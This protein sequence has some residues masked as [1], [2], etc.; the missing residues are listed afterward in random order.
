MT[1][2]LSRPPTSRS[3]RP[4]RGRSGSQRREQRRAQRAARR[5]GAEPQG[6]RSLV[7]RAAAA[8]FGAAAVTLLACMALALVGWFLADGGAHGQTTDA[9]RV[10]AD[11]WLAGHGSGISVGGVPLGIIPLTVTA[12][13]VLAV[14]RTARR[15]GSSVEDMDDAAVAVGAVTFTGLYVVTAVVTAL[16]A[17]TGT[18]SAGVGRSILGALV[19]SGIA[20]T[21]GLASG[22]GRLAVWLERV[23]GWIRAVGTGAL[24]TVLTLLVCASVL[25]AGATLWGLNDAAEMLAGLRLS[26]GDYVAYLVASAFVAPNA[27]V[28]GAAW[29]LGPGFAVGTGTVISPTVVSLGPVPAFPLVAALPDGAQVPSWLAWVMAVPVGCAVVGAVLAQ[30]SYRVTAWDSAALRGFGSGLGAA[31][32]TSLAALVAGGPMGTGRMAEIGPSVSEVFVAATMAMS[33]AGL[34]AGLV[35]AGLQRAAD[36]RAEREAEAARERARREAEERAS[37]EAAERR[38]LRAFARLLSRLARLPRLRRRA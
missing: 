22:C 33:L 36:R 6:Q 34:V 15:A 21:L 30:R 38:P 13:L 12:G 35:T 23:P 5:L 20:G 25:V 3:S 18:V 27:V 9:L 24:A 16:V 7:L 37:R 10:G 4:G 31:V 26:T 1:D 2:L 14:Y 17:S 32:L 28:F 8:S 29:L 19:V 11:L